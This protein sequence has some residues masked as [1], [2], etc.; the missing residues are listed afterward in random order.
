LGG[1]V[2]VGD[3]FTAGAGGV[4]GDG[5]LG[6]RH[7]ELWVSEVTK[8][9]LGVW[10]WCWEGWFLLDAVDDSIGQARRRAN[11][12]PVARQATAGS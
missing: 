4:V 9:P 2:G 10:K 1:A 8:V 5:A 6:G 12:Q 3:E 7:D 11:Q